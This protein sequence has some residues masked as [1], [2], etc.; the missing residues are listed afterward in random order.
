MK[1]AALIL[2]FVILL[3]GVPAMAETD[4]ILKIDG[5]AVSL[6]Q[7]PIRM[8]NTV[9]LPVREVFEAMGMK[10]EWNNEKSEII[11]SANDFEFVLKPNSEKVSV[12][13]VPVTIDMPVCL[14]EDTAFVSVQLFNDYMK[15]CAEGANWENESTLNLKSPDILPEEEAFDQQK[16][17]ASLS[18]G[19]VILNMDKVFSAKVAGNDQL[20][21]KTVDIADQPFTKA[22]EAETLKKPTNLYDIQL[23]TQADGDIAIG[24]VAV[25]SYYARKISTT[26]ESG[27]GFIGP[28][29]EQNYGDY[30]KLA[31]ISQEL[32]ENWKKYYV[33]LSPKV[34]TMPKEKSHLTLRLGYKPQVIQI[35]DVKIE[36][37]KTKYKYED[38]APKAEPNDTYK[39]IEEGALWRSEALKRIEKIRKRDITVNVKTE[40]G[41][42]IPDASVD[43]N[44]TKNEFMFGTAVHN[45]FLQSGVSEKAVKYREA[46]LDLF[47]TVVYDNAGKWP[48]IEANKGVDAS[49][50]LN[51]A[52]QNNITVRGHALFWDKINSYLPET[53]KEAYPYMSD[54]Q[55]RDRIT[56]HVNDVMTQYKG[57]IPQWDVLNEPL[58]NHDILTRLGYDEIV[59]HF[60]L[61]KA[62][63]PEASLYINETG[64]AGREAHWSN[65]YKLYDLVKNAKNG[66]AKVDGIGI[67]AHCGGAMSYPQEF[68]NQ[69]DYLSELVDEIAI[70]EYDFTPTVEAMEAPYLRDMLIV[71]YS[72]PKCTGFLTWGF[73]D[74]QHWKNH[75]PFYKS[76]WTPRE[77]VAVWKEYVQGEWNT[78][79][80]GNT[81]ETGKLVVS[82]HRG[83]YD[84][85]VKYGNKTT[86]GKL[87]VSAEGANTMEVVVSRNDMSMRASET[88]L[89][90][91]DVEIDG[92]YK[93]RTDYT[94]DE[95]GNIS[96]TGQT[97][98]LTEFPWEKDEEIISKAKGENKN[99][100]VRAEKPVVASVYA[101]GR[102]E[103]PSL[104]DGDNKTVFCTNEAAP[105]I[106]VEMEKSA[107]IAALTVYWY[108]NKVYT[109]NYDISVSDN[110][111]EWENLCSGRS[112]TKTEAYP[113]NQKCRYIKIKSL[114]PTEFL[115]IADINVE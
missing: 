37:F 18:G 102:K 16:V 79:E 65:V 90:Y 78:H 35:A 98:P 110:G 52:N 70:T 49:G 115:G 84:I 50:I 6:K 75:A 64:I 77:T 1:K 55:I 74:Q 82:G 91:K 56:E 104:K 29:Y 85:T 13:K 59:R 32:D 67:Q 94:V 42:P 114:N 80:Q 63:D 51:W 8:E 25:L 92:L 7:K 20:R 76:D 71:A 11:A 109:Y 60:N 43:I 66:G 31:S 30:I 36:N 88:P 2:A 15:Y 106:I 81:D 86:T 113:I 112:K 57:A 22:L 10:V 101:A 58:N 107:E 48:R 87:L 68:Y 53:F 40:N 47:N 33:L 54:D 46:V 26:D 99:L 105:E 4:F 38:V 44:M 61:A 5:D 19:Q 69:L 93:Y 23:V 21:L 95:K 111:N 3:G 96:G 108:E 72:H 34:L 14:I 17:L 100:T 24:D 27:M 62:I 9:L 41:T 12:D 45:T 73:W 103:L 39:G 97:Y 89:S 83:E 28:C